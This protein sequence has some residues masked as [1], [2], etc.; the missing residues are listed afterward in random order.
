LKRFSPVGLGF[1]IFLLGVLSDRLFRSL[2]SNPVLLVIDDVM[3]GIAVGLLVFVYERRRQR[4][5]DRKLQVIR[6]MNHHV[7][8]ALQVLSYSTWRQEDENLRNM[9]RDSVTH[10]DWALREVLP[11]E[12][13]NSGPGSA[14]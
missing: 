1:S 8:N 9:M 4:D 10:I 5:T 2:S 14:A 11:G 7:R 6:E 12:V 3:A 13:G